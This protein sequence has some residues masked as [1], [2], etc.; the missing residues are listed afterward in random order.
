M[1]RPIHP[2]AVL[3]AAILLPGTGQVLNGTPPRGLTFLFFMIMLGW[4]SINLMPEHGS[5]VSRTF[6]GVF[7]YGLSVIDAYK[8]ARVNF[9]RWRHPRFELPDLDCNDR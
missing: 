3:A 7:I 2:Y 8:C 4:V 5:F 6:G 9:E 1:T